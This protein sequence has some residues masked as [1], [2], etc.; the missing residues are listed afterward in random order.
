MNDANSPNLTTFHT[1]EALSYLYEQILEKCEQ[2]LE[3]KS[4]SNKWYDTALSISL[5]KLFCLRSRGIFA[6]EAKHININNSTVEVAG[7]KEKSNEFYNL[8]VLNW[9]K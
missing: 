3:E 7:L 5:V 8:K 2:V 1:V 6:L 4:D 9:L